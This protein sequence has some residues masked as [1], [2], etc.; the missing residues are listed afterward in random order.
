MFWLF[1]IYLFKFLG[2]YTVLYAIKLFIKKINISMAYFRQYPLGVYSSEQPLKILFY[3]APYS[4]MK[5]E[6]TRGG[7]AGRADI[8]ISLPLPK[9]PGYTVAHSF[10]ENN[11]NP[12]APVLTAAGIKNSGGV[13]SLLRRL[14]QPALVF[15]EKTFATSTYRRFSNVS[16]MSMVSEGRKQFMFEYIFTPKNAAESAV[17]DDIVGTFRKCSYPML[18]SGLPERSYPQR[19]WTIDVIPGNQPS[20][21][22]NSLAAEFLGEPL[23]CV[24]KTVIVK[25]NDD[26]DPIVRF[27]P[28]GRSNVTLL[29]LV[30]QEFETGTYVPDANA[31]WSKSEIADKYL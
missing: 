1:P 3:A 15:Y 29:G 22:T 4:L 18:A 28:D 7:V 10:A 26:A 25:R 23:V 6:R 19:L 11:D 17:V 12:V 27:L 16:E 31:I 9:D 14:A 13:I 21:Y 8:I 2:L 5:K 20:P 24:L 30:F